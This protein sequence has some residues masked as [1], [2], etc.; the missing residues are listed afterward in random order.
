MGLAHSTG[1]AASHTTFPLVIPH[2][3]NLFLNFKKILRLLLTIK[4]LVCGCNSVNLTVEPVMKTSCHNSVPKATL[5][6]VKLAPHT[7]Q[8]E[9]LT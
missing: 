8:L 3:Q 6:G 4:A 1:A 5:W 2:Y 7:R 9:I